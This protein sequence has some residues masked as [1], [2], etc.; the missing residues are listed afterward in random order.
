MQH[1][2]KS[3][4]IF[5]VPGHKK[6][7][8]GFQQHEPLA[9]IASL[10]A[11][12]LTGLD[13]LHEPEGVIKEAQT[14]LAQWSK[15]QHSYFLVGGSTAGNLVMLLAAF[16]PGDVVFVQR[17]CHK[18]VLNGLELARLRPVFLA[19]DIHTQGQFATGISLSVVKKALRH[20]PDAKGIMLTNPNY[21]GISR[22]LK[23]LITIMHEHNMVVLVDE[24]H[25][26]HFGGDTR[27]PTNA[28]AM[29]ADLVVQSAHKTLPALTMGA[30]LHSNSERIDEDQVKHYL[31]MIQ[32]SS[33]SYPIMAS[34]DVARN[35]VQH[36][37]QKEYDGILADISSFREHLSQIATITVLQAEGNDE[38]DPLKV[39]IQSVTGVSGFE[40]QERLEA[41]GIYTELADSL[42][43]LFILPLGK[44]ENKER[45]LAIITNTLEQASRGDGELKRTCHTEI[46]EISPL[47]QPYESL[48]TMKKKKVLIA[49][50]VGCVAAEALIPYPPGIPLIAKGEVITKQQ[51]HQFEALKR[52]GAR[53]H[54]GQNRVITIYE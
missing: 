14:L 20:Y 7:K 6:G 50:A 3:K 36:L 13:D 22:D 43:V 16:Q 45:L 37:S 51:L 5:Y 40:L 39:T 9:A 47:S 41:Q 48:R 4:G 26:A 42:N 27:L 52:A 31:Q 44:I 18:S 53:F 24:A 38:L 34:L 35:Y 29:G 19:P 30:F 15:A 17:N 32:S 23:E 25:G 11:T 28:I 46:P 49:D 8:V 21:Y 1:A 12:E 54:G 2:E 33:P 10:D